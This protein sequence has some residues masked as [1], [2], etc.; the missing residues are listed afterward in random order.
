MASSPERRVARS[1]GPPWRRRLR[2]AGAKFDYPAPVRVIRRLVRHAGAPA[3]HLPADVFGITR[4]ASASLASV[5]SVAANTLL[6]RAVGFAE[7]GVYNRA[8]GL[9]TLFC[10]RVASLL[11]EALYPVM[12]RVP[13][14]SQQ[15]RRLSALV[16]RSPGPCSPWPSCCPTPANRSSGFSTGL[17]GSA[18]SA[19][20]LDR[21]A[22]GQRRSLQTCYFLLLA[23]QQQRHCFIAD[24]IRLGGSLAALLLALPFGLTAYFLPCWCCTLRSA[25]EPVLAVQPRRHEREEPGRHVRAAGGRLCLVLR[26][27]QSS[28]AVARSAP[29]AVD[30]S[31]FRAAFC[32][33]YLVFLRVCCSAWMHELIL[34]MPQRHRSRCCCGSLSGLAGHLLVPWRTPEAQAVGRLET[35]RAARGAF[36]PPRPP[37]ASGS[38]QGTRRCPAKPGQGAAAAPRCGA[39][40]AYTE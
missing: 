29:A 21:V 39:A 2:A 20:A 7:L 32:V 6:T 28:R 1:A 10:G 19:S 34:Y 4:I 14:Q 40:A 16:T 30:R 26:R 23:H 36:E 8:V 13:T 35:P 25:C 38:R 3:G 12:A 15:F 9:A 31:L 5:S 33:A 22:R 27:R 18:R 24:V 17:G 37:C 11:L